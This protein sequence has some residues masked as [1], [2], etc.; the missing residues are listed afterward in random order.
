M[1][2]SLSHSVAAIASTLHA[3]GT[4]G[5]PLYVTLMLIAAL[6]PIPIG[7]VFNSLIILSGFLFGWRVGFMISYT[8]AV[9][10]AVLGFAVGRRVGVGFGRLPQWVVG[11]Q[12]AVAEGGFATIFLFRLTPLPLAASS[13]LLGA[14]QGVDAHAHAAATA[15]AFLRL[16]ANVYVGSELQEALQEP[17]GG[18]LS[19]AI[20]CGGAAAGVLAVG[21]L[22][23]L[24]LRQRA[25]VRET[26]IKPR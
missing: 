26:S 10:G 14:M 9:T 2:L 12:A 19:W 16:A 22:G 17:Q 3:L 6:V 25:G 18:R 21:N 13:M 7:G 8:T 4:A 23:R 11:L 1:S 15:L 5:L 24:L 20:R